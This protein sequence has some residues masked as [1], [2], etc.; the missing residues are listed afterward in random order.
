M[1]QSLQER[2]ARAEKIIR[3]PG[4]YKICHGCESIL[5]ADVSACPNCHAYRFEEDWS[6]IV[7]QAKRLS[8]RERTTTLVGDFI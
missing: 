7:A 1:N 2:V 3:D 5:T 8:G 6:L 4:S